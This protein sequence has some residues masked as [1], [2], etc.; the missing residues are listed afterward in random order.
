MDVGVWP[1]DSK[2]C[3]QFLRHK[4]YL[5]SPSLLQSQY[6]IRVNR[7][8]HHEGEFVITFPY[9]YHSG[10]NLGY[11][12]AES[13]NFATEAWLQY[14]RVAKKCNCTEDS[15][16]IDVDDIERKLRG[17]ETEYEETDEDEGADVESQP[18]T[19]ELPTPPASVEGKST[20]RER[21]RKRD[22]ED[23]STIKKIRVRI[24]PPARPPCVLCPNDIPTEKLL[25]TDDGQQAHKLCALY[26]PETFIQGPA[27]N[28]KIYNIA[29][30]NKARL[31][32]KC[33]FCRSMRGACF[34]CSHGKCTRAY[35]ATCAA[36]GGVL[37]DVREIPVI[38]E[39]GKEYTDLGIEFKCKFHR[40]KRPKNWDGDELEENKL[41]QDFAHKV[42]AGDVIQ[43]Q[44]LQG[45]IFAGVIVEKRLSEKT[46]LMDVLPKG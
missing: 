33:N 29:N 16:W 24:K 18:G 41:V 25:P 43:V 37:V 30:I 32:L 28:E 21:K 11:N 45:D 12:C 10:Y 5:I 7:L 44:F 1:A 27:D 17:D 40:P 34:Q 23:H 38:G 15:V 22:S 2:Q 31:D 4:T 3:S 6:N 39:D 46:V 13:V 26:I 8:V 19:T 35:H 20:K 42:Q 9:G 14:G 36:A